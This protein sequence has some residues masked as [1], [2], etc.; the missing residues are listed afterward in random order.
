MSKHEPKIVNLSDIE[1]LINRH[2]DQNF[3]I[4]YHS[5]PNLFVVDSFIE[6]IE[7]LDGNC[8]RFLGTGKSI[9]EAFTDLEE[10]K[11]KFLVYFNG[12]CASL[13]RLGYPKE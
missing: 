13:K 3:T 12:I 11:K 4:T 8:G 6:Y 2:P 5:A 10:N 7:E 9:L 1:A